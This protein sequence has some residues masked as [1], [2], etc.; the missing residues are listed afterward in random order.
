ML[1]DMFGV[2]RKEAFLDARSSHILIQESGF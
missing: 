1:G 2:A